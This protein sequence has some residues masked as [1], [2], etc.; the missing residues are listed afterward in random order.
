MRPR[1]QPPSA[2]DS[3]TSKPV[4]STLE[5][6]CEINTPIE[7]QSGQPSTGEK[8][9]PVHDRIRVPVSYDDLSVQEPPNVQ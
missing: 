9:I 3:I 8:R 2:S 5:N 7:E 6:D 1:G 4:V